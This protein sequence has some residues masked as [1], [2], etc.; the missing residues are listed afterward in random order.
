LKH[1]LNYSR[2]PQVVLAMA[3]RVKTHAA[4]APEH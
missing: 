4:L 1:Y 2:S 3:Q